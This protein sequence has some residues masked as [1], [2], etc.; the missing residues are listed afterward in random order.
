MPVYLWEG[1]TVQGKVLKGE[2]EA[3]NQAAVLVR[4]RTQRIQPIPG[5]VREKG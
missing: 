4:L 5:R 2:M 3:L 1:K